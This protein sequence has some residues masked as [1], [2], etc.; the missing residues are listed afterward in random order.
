MIT[1]LYTPKL[2]LA[3]VYQSLEWLGDNAKDPRLGSPRSDPHM[4]PSLG[5]FMDKTPQS[6]SFVIVPPGIHL[7]LREKNPYFLVRL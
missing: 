6:P 4:K 5:V 1:S 2:C 7:C 3:D